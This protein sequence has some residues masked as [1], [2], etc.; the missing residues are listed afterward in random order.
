VKGL[1]VWP[2]SV[3][4]LCQH[5]W[6]H[7]RFS[8][9]REFLAKRAYPVM[10]EAAEFYL[11]WLVADPATGKLVSGPSMS[12]ENMFIAPDGSAQILCMGA[13]M[14]QQIIAELFDNCLEAAMLLGIDD[15]FTQKL[16][17]TRRRLAGPQIGTDG[18]LLEW[19]RELKERD[20]GHRHMSHLYALH[21]GWQITPRGTPELAKAARASL[22]YRLSHGGGHTGW[23][24]AWI[25]NFF[26]RLEDGAKAHEH[27]QALFA[28]STL[29]N[30]FDN[31]PPF[32][33]DGNFGGA[34]G[35]AEMLLQSHESGLGIL[36]KSSVNPPRGQDA[37]AT[38]V[39]H[40]LPALPAAWPNG[41]VTG[42]RAR[43]GF[44]AGMKWKNGKL[45]EATIRNI[46][47]TSCK[48]RYGGEVRN[49]TIRKGESKRVY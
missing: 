48:V 29:P 28:K 32:Q 13:A 12:P 3:G 30:L 9:D 45:E 46:S 16:A 42:L 47:G 5:L 25:I 44:E 35:I 7:A 4:W 23:S 19:A 21:P 20:P 39:I 34:A 24:R 2:V 40:L 31:H 22:D 6:E 15:P 36:P 11:D 38:A 33:I 8:G 1:N 26:A 27:L 37:Q 41:K 10:K 43:G 14:D 18:R 49:V 17:A